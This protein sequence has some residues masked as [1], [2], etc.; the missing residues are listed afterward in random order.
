MFRTTIIIAGFVF[1]FV[2]EVSAADKRFMI[3]FDRM[4]YRAENSVRE[5]GGNIFHRFPEYRVVSASLSEAG[6][7]RLKS[8]PHVKKIEPDP[9]RYLMSEK[10]PY[11]I[12]M[13]QADLV[14]D[15]FSGD[16]K[17][18]IIDSGF[19]KSHED[20]QDE[21]LS[22]VALGGTGNAFED[23]CGHG[24]H[25]AGIIAALENQVG[26]IGVMPGNHLRFH[27][28]KIFG[29]DCKSSPSRA[30]D[31]I[32]AVRSCRNAGSNVINMSLGGPSASAIEE[33]AFGDAFDAG[34]LS[35]AAAGNDGDTSYSYP[36]SYNSVISVGA[37]NSKGSVASFSQRNDHVEFAAPGVEVLSTSPFI[38]TNTVTVDG[39]IYQGNWIEF[40]ARSKGN[41][42]ALVNGALCDKKSASWQG[43][44]VLCKRGQIF[45]RTKVEN[46]QSSGG[47]GAVIYNNAPGN[48]SGTLGDGPASSI[49][50]ISLSQVQGLFLLNHKLK[51]EAK[52]VSQR[53]EP[54]SGYDRESGTSFS[55]PHVAGV[56]ALIWSYGPQWTNEQILEALRATAK[57]L[58]PPGKDNSYGYG[59]P[60]AKPA[61]DWLRA[62]KP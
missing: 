22:G 48:F 26:V 57:D 56:A 18:C 5:V 59:L 4:D 50:A 54:A 1:L 16:R 52:V 44:I 20:L 45:F 17:V 53:K 12:P 21:R 39:K 55:S 28:V 6:L 15:E 9:E 33:E 46:V 25:V 32:A 10:I 29:D 24:T 7:N 61:L 37:I 51:L 31:L 13:V 27:I 35:I 30:S 2:L 42:G 3:Q 62:Q 43:K 36:A 60:Q 11:G 47:I 34:I 58:G 40:A 14:S 38:E 23:R 8:D 19:Q 41:S 49:P